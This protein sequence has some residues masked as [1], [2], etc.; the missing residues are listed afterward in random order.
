MVQLSGCASTNYSK[1]YV[2]ELPDMPL[3][4]PKVASELAK[5]CDDKKCHHLNMWL[6]ELYLFREEYLIYK[7][8]LSEVQAKD[9]KNSVAAH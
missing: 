6:N 3:A 9:L 5:I 8:A 2:M 7:D 4:G 1:A